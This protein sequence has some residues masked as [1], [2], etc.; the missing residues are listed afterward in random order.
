MLSLNYEDHVITYV[1]SGGCV[2]LAH[3]ISPTTIFIGFELNGGQW[4]S[5]Q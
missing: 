2:N 1:L 4:N 5:S 3:L